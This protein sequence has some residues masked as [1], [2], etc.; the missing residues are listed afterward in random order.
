MEPETT[1]DKKNSNSFIA[2][3]KRKLISDSNLVKLNQPSLFLL[4]LNKT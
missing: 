3:I 4:S 1:L 2:L